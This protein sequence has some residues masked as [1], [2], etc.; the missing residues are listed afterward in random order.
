MNLMLKIGLLSVLVY[1][2]IY[3]SFICR[4][5]EFKRPDSQHDRFNYHYLLFSTS[6]AILYKGFNT[7]ICSQRYEIFLKLKRKWQ[8]I[9]KIPAKLHKLFI[10]FFV[11]LWLYEAYGFSFRSF[12]VF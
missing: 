4:Q 6:L 9:L 8:G 3:D 1:H 12:V 10:S 5:K 7:I 2:F 11:F